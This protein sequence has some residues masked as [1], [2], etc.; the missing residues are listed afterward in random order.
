MSLETKILIIFL[1]FYPIYTI[2]AQCYIVTYEMSNV[3]SNNFEKPEGMSEQLYNESTEGY[4]SFKVTYE[5]K[6]G[7]DTAIYSYLHQGIDGKTK[8]KVKF[9]QP[10]TVTDFVNRKIYRISDDNSF[11]TELEFSNKKW[12]IDT[13]KSKII[14][15]MKAYYATTNNQ[16]S[17]NIISIWFTNELGVNFGPANVEDV[18]GF[19]LIYETKQ[20]LTKVTEIKKVSCE[21]ISLIIPSQ[22]EW[23]N[24]DQFYSRMGASVRTQVKK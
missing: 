21:E 8:E 18:P 17:G 12:E 2:H 10:T 5:L 4:K 3:Q 15:G 24:N 16:F 6:Y 1:S 23:L 14:G 20:F 7:K 13:T 11:G 22:I 19:V 9:G